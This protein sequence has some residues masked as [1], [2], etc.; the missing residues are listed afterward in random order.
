MTANIDELSGLVLSEEDLAGAD[1]TS[2]TGDEM[3][4]VAGRVFEAVTGE[5]VT[6]QR[7]NDW[8]EGESY[9]GWIHTEDEVFEFTIE[10]DGDDWVLDVQD[11][12]GE[13][14]QVAD[15]PEPAASGSELVQRMAAAY[16]RN[17]RSI[18][19]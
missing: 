18:H 15:T 9:T 5:K 4:V 14:S 8:E 1:P 19:R 13:V 7:T 10:Q 3:T 16:D 17:K 6:L 12:E 2:A 11:S